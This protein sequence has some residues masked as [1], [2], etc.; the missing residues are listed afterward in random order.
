MVVI[1]AERIYTADPLKM[2]A[3]EHQAQNVNP[4]NL[5]LLT[6]KICASEKRLLPCFGLDGKF[7]LE[8]GPAYLATFVTVE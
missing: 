3:E 7:A 2:H 1:Q 5:T 4:T 8:L 6:L